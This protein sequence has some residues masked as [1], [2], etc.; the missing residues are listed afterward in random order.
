MPSI[1]IKIRRFI[2]ETINVADI[3]LTVLKLVEEEEKQ[4][5]GDPLEVVARILEEEPGSKSLDYVTIEVQDQNSKR[6]V[7]EG[8]KRRGGV[9]AYPKPA[10]LR[11]VG[12]VRTQTLKPAGE[13]GYY[14]FRE[15]D[16]E[17]YSIEDERIH[18]H[19]LTIEAPQNIAFLVIE[20]NE[21]RS[22]ARIQRSSL[23]QQSYLPQPQQD[24]S[25]ESSAT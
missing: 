8:F 5:Y 22:I 17:W 11:R 1:N 2:R 19:D 4:V 7:G 25:N 15:E 21:G 14:K 6:I 16:I 3:K 12:I 18:V 10:Q 23:R 13:T 20:T 24:Q 9:L